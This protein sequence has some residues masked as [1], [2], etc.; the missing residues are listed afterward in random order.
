M[1][2]M[3]D[4]TRKG[5]D[6]HILF[7]E[8]CRLV[9]E[10]RSVRFRVKGMSMFPFLRN[11]RDWAVLSPFSLNDIK[12]GAIVLA[13]DNHNNIILHRIIKK[14]GDIILL[15]GD[16]NIDKKEKTFVGSIAG[17]VSEVTRNGRSI[18]TDSVMWRFFSHIWYILSPFRKYLLPICLRLM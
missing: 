4:I 5:M 17:I 9:K 6:N 14:D 18:R 13:R 11:E 2:V 16:G 8:I 3:K 12:T 10:G 7:D 1:S 15:S